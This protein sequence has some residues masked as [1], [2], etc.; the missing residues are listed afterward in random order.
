[1]LHLAFLPSTSIGNEPMLTFLWLSSES[2]LQL[3]TRKLSINAH[4]FT[5]ASRA[6]DVVA[7]VRS[8]VQINA[9][10]DFNDVPFSC[11]AARRVL[12]IPTTGNET[13]ALVVGDEHSVLYSISRTPQSPRISRLSSSTG[14][15]KS[16]RASA[17]RRS[18]QTEMMGSVGKR[19]KSSTASK[20]LGENGD[21]WEVRPVWRVRQGFGTVLA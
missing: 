10:T 5:D 21:K 7:P 16:P 6:I 15:D 3:Q 18:P 4:S 20:S 12:P 13:L 1:L 9:E 17:T 14:I 8:T 19:R 2:A 11:P